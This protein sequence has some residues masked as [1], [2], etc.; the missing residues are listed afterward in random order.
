MRTRRLIG[1]LAALVLT[2]LGVLA[3]PS[4]AQATAAVVS[5]ATITNAPD[6]GCPSPWAR[7]SYTR[8]TTITPAG[9][10]TYT[11]AIAD[12][13]T[14]TTSAGA[15]SPGSPGTKIRAKVTG[16]LTGSGQ[17]TVTGQLLGE[18]ALA[19]LNGKTYQRGMYPNKCALPESKTTAA[20]PL[21]FFEPEATTSGINPWKWQYKTACET[22]TES[23]TAGADGNIV[24]RTCAATV[25]VTEATCK[26]P[27]SSVIVTNPNSHATLKVSFGDEP[28]YAVLAGKTAAYRLDGTVTSVRV[29]AWAEHDRKVSAAFVETVTYKAPKACPAP[30]TGPTSNAGFGGGAP[31]LPKTGFKVSAAAG[32]AGVLLAGGVVLLVVLRRRR[33]TFTS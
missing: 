15:P 12:Q 14:F 27:I 3:A 6:D 28:P 20:W 31:T 2:G 24:G 26:D 4:A 23:S 21:Q 9:E 25:T 17:F 30:T 18:N 19:E 13:G 8:T 32:T 22:R 10:G 7:D 5:T 33:V 1:A 16:T 29:S 11:V